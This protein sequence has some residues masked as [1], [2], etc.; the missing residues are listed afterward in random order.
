MTAIVEVDHLTKIY[1]N[2]WGRPK[3]CA[4]DDLNFTMRPGEVLGLIGPNGAGKTTTLKVLLGL[5]RPS[6]GRVRLFG[7]LPSRPSVKT[8]LGFLPEES[9]LYRFLTP[10]ETLMFFGKLFG[11]KGREL[12]KKIPELLERVGLAS[13]LHKSV[14]EFSKGMMRRLGLAQALINDPE[15]LILD[16]PTSGLD[17]LGTREVKDLI[18]EQKKQGKSVLLCSHLLADMESVCDRIVMMVAGRRCLFDTV[19]N[20]LLKQ[21][22]L[23]VTFGN[24]TGEKSREIERKIQEFFPEPFEI[25]RPKKNLE[26]LFLETLSRENSIQ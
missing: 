13:V 26:Q 10:Y 17:P 2:F 6:A 11:M 9:Y 8:R 7:Q 15:L 23:T 19:E 12:A 21:D 25:A 16:E 4:V 24:V 1:K 14:G 18:L 20:L 3:H 5:L 22:Q